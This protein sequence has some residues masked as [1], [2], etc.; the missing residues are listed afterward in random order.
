MDLVDV[1]VENHLIRFL[2]AEP[3]DHQEAID[4]ADAQR[5]GPV[6][7]KMLTRPKAMVVV[8]AEGRLVVHGTRRI[9]VARAAAREI[10]LRCGHN[11]QGMVAE[12]GPVVVSFDLEMEL[13]PEALASNH[14]ALAFDERLGCL[15]IEDQRYELELLVWPNGRGVSMDAR[16]ANLV[17]M[18]ALSWRKVLASMIE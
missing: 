3:L 11:D 18:A 16:H 5:H 14:R 6:V 8:D 12:L 2:P 15:R 4:L 13:D 7:I 10:L 1:S 9:E 17:A